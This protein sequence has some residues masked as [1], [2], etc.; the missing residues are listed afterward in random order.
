MPNLPNFLEFVTHIW[1]IAKTKKAAIFS[2]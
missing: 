1:Q 2:D